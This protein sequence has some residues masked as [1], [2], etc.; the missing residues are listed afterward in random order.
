M[1]GS[2]AANDRNA[3]L[4][5]DEED[6]GQDDGLESNKSAELYLRIILMMREKVKMITAVFPHLIPHHRPIT[7]SRLLLIALSRT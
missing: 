1:V 3:G 5:D 2:K 4:Y 7:F 6:D